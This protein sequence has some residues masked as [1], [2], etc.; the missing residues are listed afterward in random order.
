M[1]SIGTQSPFDGYESNHY[2][3]TDHELSD[4]EYDSN[5]ESD[6][7]SDAGTAAPVR[8]VAPAP[9]E[10]LM[11]SAPQNSLATGYES[12]HFFS[13]AA[14]G[15]SSGEESGS[16][17]GCESDASALTI[18][19]ENCLSDDSGGSE[20]SALSDGFIVSD[21]YLSD[22]ESSGYN[23]SSVSLSGSESEYESDTGSTHSSVS[24]PGAARRSRHSGK[25]RLQKTVSRLSRRHLREES[26]SKLDQQA[27]EPT[28]KSGVELLGKIELFQNLTEHAQS[29]E[30]LPIIG[31]ASEARKLIRILSQPRVRNFPLLTGPH[32]IGKN[33]VLKKLIEEIN[34]NRVPSFLKGRQVIMLDSI[35]LFAKQI[36]GDG[37]DIGLRI[38]NFILRKLK[39]VERP[40]LFIKDIDKLYQYE[41]VPEYLES[42][43]QAKIPCVA[44]VATSNLE[45]DLSGEAKRSIKRLFH[46]FKVKE[47]SAQEAAR[48]T[49][50]YLK[51]HPLSNEMTVTQDAINTAVKL[52]ITHIKESP[53]PRKAIRLI[54]RAEKETLLKEQR[55]GS[56]SAP[57]VLNRVDI[58]TIIAERT[59]ID[60]EQLALSNMENLQKIRERFSQSIIGQ[61]HAIDTV[62]SAIQ[63][64]KMGFSDPN[65]PWGVFLF[66]GP[67]GV[68]KT[69]FAKQ[70]ATELL[71]DQRAMI[72][73]DMS[74]YAES[75]TISRLI[76]A[77]PGYEGHESG[78]Q[79][80]KALRKRP[81]TVVLLDEI[82]KGHPD[83]L[84]TFLQV[85]DDGR[86]TDGQG[87]TVDCTQAIFLMTSNLGSKEMMAMNRRKGVGMDKVLK[88]VEPLIIEHLTPEL[89]GRVMAVVP[90]RSLPKKEFPQIV[91][92]HL[93]KIQERV[94]TQ[95]QLKLSWS[96]E[97]NG[98]FSRRKYDTSLGVRAMCRQI[99]SEVSAALTQATL[100]KRIPV[101][102]GEA[103]LSIVQKKLV[104]N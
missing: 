28:K 25:N 55:E 82:E 23:P 70:I 46:P 76:G 64:Y 103:T 63:R 33:A 7:E 57:T 31:R 35:S 67:T 13:D 30:S 44:S 85:F 96:D 50:Q 32:G 22:G 89:Y 26:E 8:T 104:V 15:E 3:A 88:C 39:R 41:L 48:I 68:G 53:L 91:N 81:H 16:E 83:I 52:S 27:A 47:C 79:L 38:K 11:L 49:E 87:N 14:A 19:S 72:R 40:L 4:S 12:N 20:E 92:V 90:F 93:S 6:S 51:E 78:G 84:R 34:A 18:N 9:S 101:E 73:L 77:P 24:S 59:G 43:L 17:S 66:V 65:K 60:R 74:E 5:T 10:S 102:G 99:G 42:I 58:A 1:A 29:T 80:T 98:Y 2:F 75:H 45:E 56:S 69:E 97:V 100:T 86:L 62:F 36:S 94:H 21:E 61:D 71:S 54:Q 95:K 37:S